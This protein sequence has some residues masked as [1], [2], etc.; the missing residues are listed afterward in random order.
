MDR[1]K[2]MFLKQMIAD[3][4]VIIKYLFLGCLGGVSGLPPSQSK[5]YTE[6]KIK[7]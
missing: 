7:N 1:L 5:D 3:Y 4:I 6:I 2:A